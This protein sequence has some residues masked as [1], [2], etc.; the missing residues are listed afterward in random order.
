MW[1]GDATFNRPKWG[2]Y[3]SLN[4]SN[5]LRD[6]TVLFSDFCIA[7]GSDICP[8]DVA[9]PPPRINSV[10]MTGHN[11]V[12]SGT[13]GIPGWSYYV[14]ASTNI[15]LPIASWTRLATN[16]FSV[17]GSFAITNGVNPSTAQQFY[18]LQ[19]SPVPP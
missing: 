2:I 7:K 15:N 19:L 1:R 13:N 9:V 10:T 5:Y 17:G 3:R 16:V 18:R 8:S 12:F 4:S 14:L 11:L 6:E